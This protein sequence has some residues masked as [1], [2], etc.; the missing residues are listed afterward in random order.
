MDAFLRLPPKIL[1]TKGKRLNIALK[2]IF[3]FIKNEVHM[4]AVLVGDVQWLLQTFE[5]GGEG[6]PF[7]LKYFSGDEWDLHDNV[8]ASDVIVMITD[9]VSHTVRRRVLSLAA[10]NRVSLYMRHSCG[11]SHIK[12]CMR[13]LAVGR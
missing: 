5:R 9:Q 8:S 13:G 7:E 1:L 6:V 2:T 10:S 11:A 4:G 3:N 12:S